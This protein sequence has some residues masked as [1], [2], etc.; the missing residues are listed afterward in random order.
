MSAAVKLWRDHELCVEFLSASRVAHKFSTHAHP[1]LVI[2]YFEGGVQTFQAAGRRWVAQAGDLLILPPGLAHDGAP[3]AAEGYS[4][5]AIYV[6]VCALSR[7]W[8][9]DARL[10]MPTAPVLLS[11]S[12]LVPCALA[13]HRRIETRGDSALGRQE[14]LFRLLQRSLMA[15]LSTPESASRRA[16]PRQPKAAAL[17]RDYLHAHFA[18]DVRTADLAAIAGI[19]ESR[20]THVF[21]EAFHCSPAVYH[22]A[23]RLSAARTLIRAGIPLAQAASE[24][25][26]ADQAHLTRRFKAAFGVTPGQIV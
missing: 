7:L 25:G 9:T 26:F 18:E 23:L 8:M 4:Y 20:L 1:E 16:H 5:R 22:T 10:R 11:G 21:S 12:A 6:D 13:V 3:V 2:A 15:G 24:V 17:A 14:L 19:S